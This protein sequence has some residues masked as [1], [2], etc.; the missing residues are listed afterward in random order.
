MSSALLAVALLGVAGWFLVLAHGATPASRLRVLVEA[1]SVE[2]VIATLIAVVLVSFGAFRPAATLALAAAVPL[3]TLATLGR[4]RVRPLPDGHLVSPRDWLLLLVLVLMAPVV[5]PRMEE[6]RMDS[7]AGVYSNRAIH[8]LQTGGL[9]GSIPVRD[10]LE[11]ELLSVFDRDNMIV[12]PGDAGGDRPGN[13]LPGTYVLSPDRTRFDFQFFPGW[14]M[15][16]ALW[17]GIFGIPQASTALAFLYALSIIL[18]SLILERVTEGATARA[19]TVAIF[20]SS[21]LLLF[22]FLFV[23][24]FLGRESRRGAVLAAAGVLLLAVSHSSTFLYAPLLLLP[25]LEAYRSENG[26]MALFSFLAFAAL[27]AGLPLGHFF[28]PFY[29]RDIFSTSFR[30]LPVPDPATA[31]LAVVAAFYSAGCVLSLALLARAVRPSARPAAWAKGAERLLATA[32][33]PALVLVAIWTAWRGYQLGWTDRFTQHLPGGAWSFREQYAGQGWPSLAHLDIVSMV[34]ATSLVGLPTVLAL[35]VFRGRKVSAS[36]ARAFLLSTVL[37]T[38]AVF[39]FFRVDTP[40]NYYASRYFLPVFVPATMLLLGSLLGLFRPPRGWLALVGLVALAFNLYFDRGLYRYPSEN[41]KLRFVEQ[42][43]RKVGGNRVLFVRAGEP[44]FQLLAVLLQSLHGI[45]VV[46]VAHLRGEPE[47][48]TVERYAARLSLTDAAVLSTVA[49]AEGCAFAE[50]SM[51]ERRFTQ[52]G[53]VYPTDHSER[54]RVYYLYDL[55]FA[56]DESGKA[57]APPTP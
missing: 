30:F 25:L 49:P 52:R 1:V 13:Y 10:R 41:E 57:A 29:L 35:A 27:L 47:I 16:M 45:S 12:P 51:R 44:T 20:A 8:H 6:L 7:D 36:P 31:G 24:H 53:I 3:A 2:T 22:L 17:G 55:V 11:G 18:F 19:L 56:G 39:T 37:W 5:L 14:P 33:A 54:V 42:V 15:V 28:S 9:H 48:T 40:F 46:R 50:L 43:A 34:L 23:L 21:P 4:M 38:L 32:V 26:R